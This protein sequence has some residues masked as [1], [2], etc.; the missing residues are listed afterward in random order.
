MSKKKLTLSAVILTLLLLSTAIFAA[1]AQNVTVTFCD[2]DGTVIGTPQT[3]KAGEAPQKPQDPT[4][5]GY[6]FAGWYLTPT[7]NRE[8]DFSP[9]NEDLKVYAQWKSNAA[10]DRQWVIAGTSVSGPLKNNS[11]GNYAEIDWDE[12]TLAKSGGAFTL[13]I[14][15]YEGDQFKLTVLRE[16]GTLDYNDTEKGANVHFGLLT[17]AGDN[18]EGLG[19]I[20]DAPKNISCKV[21]GKYKLTLN[22][23]AEN[24]E[25]NRLTAERIGDAADVEEVVVAAYYIKGNIV[26]GWQNVLEDQYKMVKEGTSYTLEIQLYGGDEF[27]FLGLVRDETALNDGIVI[28]S[29]KLDASAEN[30]TA[31]AGGNLIA[32]ADGTYSFTYDEVTKKLT[33]TYDDTF[34]L[35]SREIPDVWYVAGEGLGDL[36]GN[37]YGKADNAEDFKLTKAEGQE[38]TWTITLK[39]QVG[40][41]FQFMSDLN[42][43]NK[44]GF[45]R[46]T[47]PGEYFENSGNI[48]AKIAGEYRFTLSF[49]DDGT[50]LGTITF[51]RIG[52]VEEISAVDSY[53]IKGNKIS[54]WKDVYLEEKIMT[55]A[56]GVHTL[57]IYI[58]AG[59]EFMFASKKVQGAVVTA[60]TEFIRGSNIDEA[61]AASRACVSGTANMTALKTGLYTFT[62]TEA[63]KKL[64]VSVDENEQLAVYDY[65]V[66]G[67][68]GGGNWN[69]TYNSAYKFAQ[70][71]GTHKY[72]ITLDME[73]GQE[74]GISVASLGATSADNDTVKGFYGMNRVAVFSEA[75]F[76]KTANNIKCLKAGEYKVT[77]DAYSR[78]VTL[79]NLNPT[80][81]YFVKGTINGWAHGAA[82]EYKL[83]KGE[84]SVYSIEIT[85]PLN[86]EFGIDKCFEGTATSAGF[87]NAAALGSATGNCNSLFGTS[88][89]LKAA[90]A[91]VY[92]LE[93]DAENGTLNIFKVTQS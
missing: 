88:G 2:T 93:Y 62:F 50:I 3:V 6:T 55:L 59:D 75:D 30:V 23:D 33:V 74:F 43:A 5:D 92:R 82:V 72:E 70:V 56:D 35:P 45:D 34:T 60:G 51:E 41:Q 38:F 42:W 46:I 79:E 90:E 28:K 47:E 53:Y 21:S 14:D 9:V 8:Y 24:N 65:Y 54:L 7:S 4:K 15:L 22:S 87:I 44:Q 91:G 1:C 12:F 81:E 66:K 83:I 49:T 52:D 40:D 27:M 11:W 63:T 37:D 89:N 86:A 73:A 57:S 19:G 48:K 26:T 77:Y 68:V 61:D 39:L 25:Q 78:T 64:T 31:G 17:N 32:S 76:D 13:T 71:D 85:L 29:D 16:D 36:K 20:G 69:Q 58:E 84:G 80:Y 10:D 18:F 67:T